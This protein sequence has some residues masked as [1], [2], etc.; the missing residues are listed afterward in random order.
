MLMMMMS[1]LSAPPQ[2]RRKWNSVYRLNLICFARLTMNNTF[3][4]DSFSTSE[5]TSY[6]RFFLLIVK[7]EGELPDGDNTT[8]PL[9][10][11]PY[12]GQ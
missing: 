5:K 6:L 1:S 12:P 8:H 9:L 11:H 4:V 7:P 10:R 2:W 3:N